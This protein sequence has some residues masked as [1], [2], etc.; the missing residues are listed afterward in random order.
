MMSI[1][2]DL[3]AEYLAF[4]D[5]ARNEGKG[6]FTRQTRRT[7]GLLGLAVGCGWARLVLG[8]CRGLVKDL[9]QPRTHAREADAGDAGALKHF[10]LH[11]QTRG[12]DGQNRTHQG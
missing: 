4:F 10:Q 6:V 9:R 12:R 7:L 8:R 3:N 1:A 11:R 5:I 2:C